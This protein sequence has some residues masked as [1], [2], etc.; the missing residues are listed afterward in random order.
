[1]SNGWH[2]SKYHVMALIAAL[3][4]KFG[5]AKVYD[6]STNEKNHKKMMKHHKRRTQM[7]ASKFASQIGEV[8][9]KNT[10]G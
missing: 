1:M 6:N 8:I 7:I 5:C 9:R 4:L 10:C 3:N 2:I